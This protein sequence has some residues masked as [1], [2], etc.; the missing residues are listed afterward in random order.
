MPSTARGARDALKTALDDWK[1]GESP[2][3]WRV[4]D[5]PMTVQDFEW[6]SGA[7]L[8]EYQLIDDGRADRRQPE[9][10]GQAHG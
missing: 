6:A 2:S 3:R 7:K 9:H 8:S 1:N 5:T 10:S 4:S